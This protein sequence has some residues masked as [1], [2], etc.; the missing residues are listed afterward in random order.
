MMVGR[1]KNQQ[2]RPPQA[3]EDYVK[4]VYGLQERGDAVT[5]TALAAELG[6]TAS[7]ASSMLARLRE[8]QLVSHRPYSEA[9]LSDAGLALALGVIRRRRLI[10]SFL[11]ETLDYGWDEVEDE[12]AVM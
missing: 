11:I 10:E 8:L 4:A 3:V 12:A 2:E 5:T 6:V 9:T 7:S 1:E